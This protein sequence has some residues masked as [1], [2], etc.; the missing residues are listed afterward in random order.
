MTPKERIDAVLSGR[1]PDR[2]PFCVVDA[3]A[4]IAQNENMCYDQL[5]SLPDAGASLVVKYLDEIESDV[6]SAVAGT[7]TAALNAFGCAINISRVGSSVEVSPCIKDPEVDIPALDK[8]TIREKLLANDFVQKMLR[9]CKGVHTLAG[10]KKYIIGDVAGPFTLAA[11]MMGTEDFMVFLMEEEELAAQLIDFTTEVSA[12]LFTLLYENGCS[13]AVPA[14]PVSSG[15]MISEAMFEEWSLPALKK[16][17][18]KLDFYPYFAC[19][20][21]GASI[22]RTAHLRDLGAKYFSADYS[23]DLGAALDICGGKMAIYGNIDPAGVLLN[24]TPEEVYREACERIDTANGRP[25]IMAPGCDM[26]PATPMAN[27]KML[28][29]A[30]KDKPF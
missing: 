11:V 23:V 22:S 25:Y 18:E 7:F 27:V 8:R 29:K 30:C 21:C 26:G 10:D 15:N 3:G 5:Y 17:K 2:T 16:L 24:G 19:H 28:V 14:E 9:Q 1:K 6:Y 13:I 4:W 20:V 12:T